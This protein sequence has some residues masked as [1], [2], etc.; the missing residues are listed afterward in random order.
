MTN[1]LISIVTPTFNRAEFLE[2]TILSVLNQGYANLEYI[3][4]DGGSTDGTIEIIR[5]YEKHIACWISEPDSGMYD[6]VNKGF[7]HATGD[8]F[9]WINSDDTYLP[10]AFEVIA[11]AFGHHAEIDWIHGRTV[12]IAENGE[13][14]ESGALPLFHQSAVAKGVHGL[15]AHF[16]QQHCCFWRADLWRDAGPIPARLRYAGD[17]WL[18]KQFARH[19]ALISINFPV[20]TFRR[21]NAQLHKEGKKYGQEMISC[22]EGAKLPI[23]A[24]RFLRRLARHSDLDMRL[25]NWITSTPSYKWIDPSEGYLLKVTRSAKITTPLNPS[26]LP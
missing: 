3:I 9:A 7:A 24:R 15:C 22:Y 18:W 11:E 20:A 1:P 10:G 21:H 8:I 16:V 26:R 23:L 25:I 6:A 17:Y 12:Y 14:R 5:K 19:S 2:E 13:G 4:V